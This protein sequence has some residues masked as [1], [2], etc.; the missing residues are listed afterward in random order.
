[1]YLKMQ[2]LNLDLKLKRVL[3]ESLLAVNTTVQT[4]VP[5]HNLMTLVE[6]E[7]YTGLLKQTS[8]IML[9]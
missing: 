7:V 1:M 8:K 3:H 5:L 4:V 9:Q 2:T 6:P